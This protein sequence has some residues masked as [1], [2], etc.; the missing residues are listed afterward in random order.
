MSAYIVDKKCIDN[1]I[2]GIRLLQRDGYG[3]PRKMLTGRTESELGFVLWEMNQEAVYQRY[4]EDRA[5]WGMGQIDA[6]YK[7]PF[8][9][10]CRPIDAYKSMRTL[11]Y[12]CSEGRVKEWDLYKQL[13]ALKADLADYVISHLPE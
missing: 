10:P 11:L 2:H 1:V 7:P 6:S 8:S 12:Q 4:P 3:L 5:T 9:G 13:E